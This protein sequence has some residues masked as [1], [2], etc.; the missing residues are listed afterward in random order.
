MSHAQGLRRYGRAAGLVAF[1]A[2][3]TAF[4]VTWS[5]QIMRQAFAPEPT[6]AKVECRPGVRALIQALR[7]A[8]GSAAAQ[9]GGE[10]AALAQFR[11][12]IRP[13]WETRAQVSAACRTDRKALKVLHEIDLLRYAEEHAVRYEAVEL[14]RRRRRIQALE[15]AL[16]GDEGADAAGRPQADAS[17]V[18]SRPRPH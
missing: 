18:E 4:T 5:L 10:R 12:A 3:V 8:R 13:E 2:I 15:A 6:P 11:A 14:A 1:A 16:F 9:T 17:P 7:R